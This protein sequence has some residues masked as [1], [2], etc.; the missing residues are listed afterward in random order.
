MGDTSSG[1]TQL[2]PVRFRYTR[3][4]D[5][6]DLQQY[7]LVAEEVAQVYPELVVYDADGHPQTV[8]YHFVNAMLLNEVL[9]IDNI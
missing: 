1:L 8:R 3:E 5:P 4:I 2:R 9:A 6:S 7:G